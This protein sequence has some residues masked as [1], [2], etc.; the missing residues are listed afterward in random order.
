MKTLCIKAIAILLYFTKL[1]IF[2]DNRLLL[3][4]NPS[5]ASHVKSCTEAG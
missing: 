1:A 3:L 4:I 5:I 2:M